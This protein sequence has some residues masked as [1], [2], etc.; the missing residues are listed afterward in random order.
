MGRNLYVRNA[1]AD[2]IDG[3]DRCMFLF[4]GTSN[5]FGR[6]GSEDVPVFGGVSIELGMPGTAPRFVEVGFWKG[7]RRQSV[8]VFGIGAIS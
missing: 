4:H 5:T 8:K 1:G 2:R 3:A 7:W 6:G